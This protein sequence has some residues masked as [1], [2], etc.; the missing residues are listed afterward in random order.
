MNCKIL[1]S[2]FLPSMLS[3]IGVRYELN[4]SKA[5]PPSPRLQAADL[6]CVSA[7]LS[8]KQRPRGAAAE[9]HRGVVQGWWDRAGF[10]RTRGA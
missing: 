8:S 1:W 5:A 4:S 3:P 10:P 2:K 9:G 6:R 7:G